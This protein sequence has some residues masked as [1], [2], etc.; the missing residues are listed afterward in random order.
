MPRLPAWWTSSTKSPERAEPRV[1]GIEVGDVVAVV[2]V[3]AGVDR[4]EPD[5]RDPEPGEVVQAV[6]QAGEIADAVAVGVLVRVDVEAVDDTVAEPALGHQRA[7]PGATGRTRRRRRAAHGVTRRSGPTTCSPKTSMNALLLTRRRGGARPR[8]SRSSTSSASRSRCRRGSLATI[9]RAA[10]SSGR[11]VPGRLV[12]VLDAGEIP[13]QRRVEHV[14]APLV[15][16]DG[17]RLVLRRRPRQVH[18][19]VHRLAVPAAGAERVD[20]GAQDVRRLGHRD[21]AVGPSTDRRGGRRRH[22]GADQRRRCG[23]QRPQPR[24]VDGDQAVVGDLL[25]GEQGTHHGDALLEAA[26]AGGLVRPRCA[27]DVLVGVLAGAERDPQPAGEHLGERRRGL[28]DERRVVALPRRVDDSE[29]QRRRGHRRAQP[30][31][32]EP[33]LALPRAPRREVVRRHRRVEAGLLGSAHRGEQAARGDLLVRGVPADDGHGLPPCPTAGAVN[34][35]R[36][37]VPSLRVAKRTL[38]APSRLAWNMA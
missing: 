25:A 28:R 15:E 6:D 31:P 30:R 2:A 35:R 21:Q 10:T 37:G 38:T 33:G 4:V 9:T 23:R 26:G 36:A 27:G 5:A 24:L 22:R 11:D 16:G 29:R 1:H 19:Q 32:R 3:R 13:A 34:R 8:R 7:V 17:E 14:R 20:D 12:E 18:L